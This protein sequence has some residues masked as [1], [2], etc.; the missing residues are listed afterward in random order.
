L[1]LS[2]LPIAGKAHEQEDFQ[3][4]KEELSVRARFASPNELEAVLPRS[5]RRKKK[6]AE[7][8]HENLVGEKKSR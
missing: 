4:E 8:E 2:D 6:L 1:I 3:S 7:G 5:K